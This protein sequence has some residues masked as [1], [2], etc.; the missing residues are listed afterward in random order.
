MPAHAALLHT[1]PVDSF[2]W[3]SQP[4]LISRGGRRVF[5]SVW[6]FF[7]A[8]A[9]EP[10]SSAA[11]C[12]APVVDPKPYDRWGIEDERRAMLQADPKPYYEWGIQD[13][14]NSM[15]QADFNI[16]AS[17]TNLVCVYDGGGRFVWKERVA[18]PSG[19]RRL[20]KG[21]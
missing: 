13:E 19:C 21:G 12:Q 7:S 9:N 6:N 2:H 8:C 15:L 20:L 3:V 16:E 14:R 18:Y 17:P 1:V 11:Q 5:L 4:G 10:S